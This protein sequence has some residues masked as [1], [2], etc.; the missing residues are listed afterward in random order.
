MEFAPTK[1]ARTD[2]LTDFNSTKNR[3]H[4]GCYV[5]PIS[6]QGPIWKTEWESTWLIKKAWSF[7]LCQT[8][9]GRS[10]WWRGYLR[11]NTLKSFLV[12]TDSGDG[13]D[14]WLRWDGSKYDCNEG[15]YVFLLVLAAMKAARFLLVLVRKES[16]PDQAGALI[17][18][19]NRGANWL[20]IEWESKS[21]NV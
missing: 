1:P 17:P 9:S 11:N 6:W 7:G 18:R 16:L 13:S 4:K 20:S 14:G 12:M 3:G 2:K 19:G 21:T 8:D 5:E 10:K 15:D